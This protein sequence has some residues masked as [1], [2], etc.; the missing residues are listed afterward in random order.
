MQTDALQVQLASQR[1]EP[2]ISQS[3]SALFSLDASHPH[4]ASVIL[5]GSHAGF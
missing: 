3:H 5:G 2:C 1:H 4:A